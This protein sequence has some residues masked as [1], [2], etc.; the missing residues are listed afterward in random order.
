MDDQLRTYLKATCYDFARS[1]DSLVKLEELATN[2]EDKEWVHI[3]IETYLE[4]SPFVGAGV[5]NNWG[6]IKDGQFWK[7]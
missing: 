4:G 1:Y 7:Q 2:D 3:F 5:D 6:N